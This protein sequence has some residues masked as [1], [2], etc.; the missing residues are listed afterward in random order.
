MLSNISHYFDQNFFL[1]VLMASLFMFSYQHQIIHRLRLKF[2]S[3]FKLTNM[4]NYTFHRK[5]IEKWATSVAQRAKDPITIHA[6]KQVLRFARDFA[7]NPPTM[8]RLVQFGYNWSMLTSIAMDGFQFSSDEEKKQGKMFF[9]DQFA[10]LIQN[11]AWNY[12]A[13][14]VEAHIELLGLPTNVESRIALLP[15]GFIVD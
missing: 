7:V 6:Q 1:G 5:Y 2:K 15:H 8:E 10:I 13:Q 3:H 9:W 11:E 14:L 4:K 12:M